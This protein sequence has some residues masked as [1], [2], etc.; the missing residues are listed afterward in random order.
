MNIIR[1]KYVLFIRK[2][3]GKQMEMGKKACIDL[4]YIIA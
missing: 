4:T 2:H 3:L 1:N